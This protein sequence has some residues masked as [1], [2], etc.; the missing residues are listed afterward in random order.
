M[1]RAVPEHPQRPRT[2][3]QCLCSSSQLETPTWGEMNAS[4][5]G[6]AQQ[7]TSRPRGTCTTAPRS[8]NAIV[9]AEISH[10]TVSQPRIVDVCWT[11]VAEEPHRS[12]I[13]DLDLEHFP[14]K[15]NA[16]CLVFPL[17]QGSRG[18]LTSMPSYHSPPSLLPFTTGKATRAHLA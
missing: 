11:L 4:T 1:P 17:H 12:T 6:G 9:H 13:L 8:R 10:I 18:Q 15:A 16:R 3:M 7:P 14:L 5:Q 2:T